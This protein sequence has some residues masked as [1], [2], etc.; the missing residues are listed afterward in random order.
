MNE[1]QACA[2]NVLVE[3]DRVC[4]EN[5]ITYY[6]GYGTLLGAVRHKGFIPWDDDVDIVMERME[7]IRF[8]KIA[9]RE[10]KAPYALIHC[11]KGKYAQTWAKVHNTETTF[12]EKTEV[13]DKNRYKGVF[14]DIF[15]FDGIPSDEKKKKA[16]L[17]KRFFCVR[18]MTAHTGIWS[19]LGKPT[20]LQRISS[21]VP[22]S[23]YFS[24]C[25]RLILKYKVEAC[26]STTVIGG[27]EQA[28]ALFDEIAY[29]DFE[30]LSFPSVKNY[31]GYLTA[32]YGD[33]MTLPPEDK[34]INHNTGAIVS[35]TESYRGFK[36]KIRI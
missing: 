6:L 27:A 8:C 12:I 31:D 21:I 11:E 14:I 15:P 4:K 24:M 19:K 10:L 33:Y 3:V 23:V 36:E 28:K 32:E 16:Y 34:R 1:V 22:Y 29:Y 26:E 5:N 17:K 25:K 2:L 35:T 7:Y 30:G 13:A 18:G 9:P 20:M